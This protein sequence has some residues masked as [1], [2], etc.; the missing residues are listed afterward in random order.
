MNYASA[1]LLT[2]A[3][4]AATGLAA[5]D[6]INTDTPLAPT[7]APSLSAGTTSPIDGSY[8]VMFKGNGV[9]AGFASKVASLGGTVVF[10]HGGAGIG[11]VA[12]L[13]PE[14]AAQLGASSGVAAVEADDMTVLSPVAGEV[15]QGVESPAAP[16]TAF[17]FARQWHMRAIG[18]DLA[19]AA[20]RRGSPNV[21]VA[22]L[23]TG[24]GYTHPDLAGRVDLAASKSFVPSDD[25][26][27]AAYFPGAHPIAD[28]HYHGT[29]VGATVSSNAVNAAGVTSGTTLIG[30][31]VCN[32]NG[33]C[34]TSGVLA[35][36][37]YAADAGAHVANLS[38]GG[39][40]NRR[41]ASAAGG[42]GPSFIAIIGRAFN[43][44]HKN[45]TQVVVSAGNDALDMDHDGN[46]YKAY[47]SAPHVVCVSAT[48]P[49]AS[50]GTNG[51]WTNV[52][53]LASYSNYGRSSVT[54]A[55]PGG[56]FSPVYAACSTF[57]LQIP[58][59]RTGAY[60]VG[61]NGTSMASPHAAGTA[62]LI[63]EDVGRNPSQIRARLQGTAD[64]LGQSGTD[65]AYGKGR[66]NVARAVGVI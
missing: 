33:S 59:C 51:P 25:A 9:P 63:A 58:V 27:V 46:G 26:L 5:C 41:D 37:V 34:P 32:V 24:L 31:K 39:A 10:A 36:V 16:A 11:A 43:Y 48:G 17:F 30:V 65:P 50:A 57:S 61:I 1:R 7:S 15:E 35:G 6:D 54:V 47:C 45:G 53:A 13:T 64:D 40:F 66:I 22:I 21:K 42:N 52:D 29:H 60:I 19:W 12:G 23:D 4:V 2:L 49:T 18:A 56:N 44:A 62:A 20:G 14:A 28:L 3:A 38:V 8:L 55:A